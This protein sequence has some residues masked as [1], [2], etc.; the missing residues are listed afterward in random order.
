MPGCPS[1]CATRTPSRRSYAKSASKARAFHDTAGLG[2][3][4]FDVWLPTAQDP[5][6]RIRSYGAVPT[7]AEVLARYAFSPA[8]TSDFG[9]RAAYAYADEFRVSTFQSG[10]AKTFRC[11]LDATGI[12][13]RCQGW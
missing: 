3:T 11:A 13:T 8:V 7:E 12:G 10:T 1:R 5:K 9:A 2:D 6:L 4:P